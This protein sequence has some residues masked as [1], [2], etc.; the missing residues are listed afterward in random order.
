VNSD[1]RTA[2][3]TVNLRSLAAG[4]YRALISPAN[5]ASA[6]FRVRMANG[7][8]G[9]VATD[10][11]LTP[12]VAELPNQL[13]YYTFNGT[14]GQNLGFSRTAMVLTPSTGTLGITINK[15][16]GGTLLDVDQ[17]R[18][19]APGGI[20]ALRNLPETGTYL[21]TTNPSDY[22][23]TAINLRLAPP[24]PGTIVLGDP[25]QSVS[26]PGQGDWTLMQFNVPATRNVSVNV[27]SYAPVPTGKTLYLNVYNSS[28]TQVGSTSGTGATRTLNINNL[29]AGNYWLQIISGQASTATMQVRIP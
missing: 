21:I 10:G 6:N 18:S 28:F 2:S 17:Q 20:D 26:L 8:I 24:I 13:A 3:A 14:T 23:G 9:S 11:T 19:W 12:V 22:V 5:A 29:P 1:V 4:T 15:P 7:A 25:A 16:S 27:T